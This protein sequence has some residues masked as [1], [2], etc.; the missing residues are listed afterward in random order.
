MAGRATL[1]LAVA[2]LTGCVGGPAVAQ[3]AYGP[4]VDDKEIKI[5]QTSPLSGPASAFGT[6]GRAQ[7]AYFQAVND[8]GGVNGRKLNFT[9]LDNAY[10]PPKALEQARRLVEEI[11]IFAE[12]GTIGTPTNS[13]TQKFM[14]DRRV[15]QL[16]IAAGGKRF[17]D[18]EHFPWT[19][20]LYPRLSDEGAI[21]AKYV[22]K[23]K[24]DAKIGLLYQNDDFGKDYL[25]GFKAALGSKVSQVVAEV[26]YELSD[27]T[28]DSQILKLKAA[29]VDALV[30]Q[31][32]PKFTA[33]AIRK[34]HE[35]NW[36]PL[37]VIGNSASSI[38][39]SLKPAG[40]EASK[41]LVT[42]QFLKQIDDPQWAN[43]ADVKTY[44]AFVAKYLPNDKANDFLVVGGYLSANAIV[45]AL[46]KCGD[47]LTRENLLK[48][49][50][51]FK[52]VALPLLLPGVVIN[53]SPD[54]YSAYRSLRI[55]RFDGERWIVEN[56]SISAR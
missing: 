36:S 49:A 15:P 46:E 47:N 5:G 33:Q 4:G 14:N 8:R 20:P 23:A 31:A 21:A 39:S 45:M 42:T 11:G 6:S 17:T 16:F 54:D 2:L 37:Y 10:S 22:L 19:V 40:L 48:Q 9:I 30:Q 25:Q 3:K 41:G 53:I 24:P 1:W 51:S 7:A 12:V 43:D 18:P 28:V 32:V 27:A 50:T 26:P 35:L 29:G 55:A 38:E 13:A 44:K 34:V 56:G 52:D